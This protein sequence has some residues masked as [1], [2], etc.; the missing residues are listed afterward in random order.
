MDDYKHHREHYDPSGGAAGCLGIV[1]LG[2]VIIGLM[3]AIGILTL[4]GVQ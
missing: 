3:F 2:I 4:A 1:I